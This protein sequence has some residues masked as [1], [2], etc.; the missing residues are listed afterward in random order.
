MSLVARYDAVFLDLDGVVYRGDRIVRGAVRVLD[1]VR[2]NIPRLFLSNNSSRTPEEVAAKLTGLGVDA[3]PEEVLTSALA[4]ASL[5]EREGASGSTAFVIGGRGLRE[6]LQSSGIRIVQ[7][8]PE[9]ADLVVVGWEG[10]VDYDRLRTASLLVQRGARLIASNADAS[11]PAPDGLWPGAGAILSVITTTTGAVP[12]VVG[13]PARPLF[14]TA[15]ERTGASHPL[16]VGDRLDTDIRGASAMG[17]D[18]LLVLT[19]TSTQADLLASDDLPTY[20][21]PDLSALLEDVPAARF[22]PARPEDLEGIRRLLESAALSAEGAEERL[23]GTIVSVT[24][25]PSGTDVRSAI[26]ATACLQMVEGA[27]I[28]RSMAV[29]QDLRGKG[30]GTLAVATA[31]RQARRQRIRS[32]SLFT[33][34]AAFFFEQLGFKRVDRS[35]L[36]ECVRESSHAAEECAA[37]AAAMTLTL[38]GPSGP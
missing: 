34:G 2:R 22:R 20:V 11:L 24:D 23:E 17:W 36:P 15:A 12:T 4:T 31:V 14:E 29:R 10:S 13:K 35:E 5:L 32:V 7:D 27:G 19:G 25:H 37:S 6:A 21:A 33:E 16:V 18:A 1:E 28:L 3:L 30:L 8:H 38:G 9:R 26:D